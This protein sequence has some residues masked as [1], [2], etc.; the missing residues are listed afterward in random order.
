MILEPWVLDEQRIWRH[1]NT[2]GGYRWPDVEMDE[3]EARRAERPMTGAEV[4]DEVEWLLDSGESPTIAAQTV[5]RTI[6]G[7]E[8]TARRKGRIALANRIY[9][10]NNTDW[11]RKWDQPTRRR[12]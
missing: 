6:A 7:L 2:F 10:A 9:A 12:A 8:R 11:K 3:L 4:L 5:G 1:L